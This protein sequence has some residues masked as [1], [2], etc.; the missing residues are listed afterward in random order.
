MIGRDNEICSKN[1]FDNFWKGGY[2]G[3]GKDK[4]RNNRHFLG[5][6]FVVRFTTFFRLVVV[7]G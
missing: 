3:V 5:W 7:S 1:N 2:V 6:V 4:R